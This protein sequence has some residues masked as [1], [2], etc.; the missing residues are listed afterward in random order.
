VGSEVAEVVSAWHPRLVGDE[1][2]AF[3]CRVVLACSPASPARARSL[4]WATS[5]LAAFGRGIGLQASEE[6]LL[7]P[8]VIERFVMVGLAGA[9]GSRRRTVRANLRFVARRVAPVQFPPDQVTVG[10]LSSARPC[11]PSEIAAYLGLAAAQPTAA[12]RMRATGL[13]CLAAG[14]GLAGADLRQVR[15]PGIAEVS[16]VL[17]VRVRG[18]RPRLVPVLAPYREILSSSAAFAGSGFL[19]GGVKPDRHNVT[20]RL[21]DSLSG[22]EDLSRLSVSRL[23]A[24]FLTDVLVGTGFPELLS[25]AGLRDSKAL[26]DLVSYLPRPSEDRVVAVIGALGAPQP[27]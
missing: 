14:A 17:C 7:C 4:L 24:S 19:I 12:R 18:L 20:H 15:G 10:R 27:R 8:S 6:A 5:R 21:V 1:E 3:A 11:S 9:S 25:A 22:G 23:R 13:I 26:F 16:G 2:A